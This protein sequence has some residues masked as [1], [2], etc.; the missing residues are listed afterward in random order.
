MGERMGKKVIVIDDS[1]TIR[2]Q[3]AT[4]L[5][6]AG[7]EILEAVDGVDGAEVIA[8][9][10]DAA[11]V[12]CDVNMPKKNGLELLEDLADA[13]IVLFS[14]DA[15]GTTTMSDGKGLAL[16]GLE[17]GERVGT[18]ELDAARGTP[19]H[20]H[21]LRALGGETVR[22][23]IEPRPGVYFETW[24]MPLR[25][26][27]NELDGVLG[28]SI[29]ATDRV[30]TERRLVEKTRVVE[31]QTET[32][33]NLAAPIIKVW[34]EVVCMP[35]VGAVDTARAT[36][37]MEHLLEA[38]V[39]EQARFAIVDLTGV[40][41]MDTSTVHHVLR[42][43]GAARMLGVEGVLSGARPSVAQTVVSLGICLDELR[44]VR[45][46]HDALS[47]CLSRR[48]AQAARRSPSQRPGAMSW[49]SEEKR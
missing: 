23:L 26:E 34:D 33:R 25:N 47:W 31:R 9:A 21:L 10:P 28:L 49:A 29:D 35:I 19:V 4:T 2:E 5:R 39:R 38:I 17:P 7:F 20:D 46:L 8:G 27:S 14:M 43:F 37:M 24:Y 30:K 12:I 16:V 13:P 18:N 40:E 3:V 15:T 22:V 11:L 45:T 41:T 1:Q 32:I 48:R 44:M 6:Q 42:L 36:D